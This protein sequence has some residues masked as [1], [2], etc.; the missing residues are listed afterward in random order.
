MVSSIGSGTTRNSYF[1][2]SYQS[3]TGISTAEAVRRRAELAEKVG[4]A[5]GQGDT[6]LAERLISSY[7]GPFY[8]EEELV[9]N[10]NAINIKE[11]LKAR[12][13]AGID[14]PE[15][16]LQAK[17][18]LI[19]P[20]SWPDERKLQLARHLDSGGRLEPIVQQLVQGPRQ[21]TL[22]EMTT[23]KNVEPEWTISVG[24]REIT[25]KNPAD[26]PKLLQILNSL[27]SLTR[28][29]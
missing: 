15:S 11:A 21:R 1:R 22:R 26:K 23:P 29:R 20:A 27:L 18:A 19:A 5:V 10:E 17:A 6:R 8:S 3:N 4:S 12:I 9:A 14:N 28:G 24:T 7:N 16:A 25:A 2:A 13:R